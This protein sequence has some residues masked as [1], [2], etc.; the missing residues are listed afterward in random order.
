[1]QL[2]LVV[3]GGQDDHGAALADLSAAPVEVLIVLVGRHLDGEVQHEEGLTGAALG[4]Q[5]LVLASEDESVDEEA[6]LG[7]L[8]HGP[9]VSGPDFKAIAV[10][11]HGADG[12]RHRAVVSQVPL[13]D[14]VPLTVGTVKGP[15]RDHAGLHPAEDTGLGF[16]EG[17][18]ATAGGMQVVSAD[19][20]ELGP[21][22]ALLVATLVDLL[23]EV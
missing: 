21:S 5:E 9:A 4:D 11:D 3:F 18:F 10:V 8:G 15:G 20:G 19:T 23:G 14:G 1:M 6:A 12:L 7:L 22:V 16:V 2:V 17:D 13:Q